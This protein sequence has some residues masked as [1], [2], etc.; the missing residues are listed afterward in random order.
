MKNPTVCWMAP[1]RSS[2]QRHITSEKAPVTK[3][4]MLSLR[5]SITQS[6]MIWFILAVLHSGSWIISFFIRNILSVRILLPLSSAL[7]VIFEALSY[8]TG[9]IR[10]MS[11]LLLC[12]FCYTYVLFHP[13]FFILSPSIE[14]RSVRVNIWSVNPAVA[15]KWLILTRKWSLLKCSKVRRGLYILNRGTVYYFSSFLMIP[16]IL[17]KL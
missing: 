10:S 9:A 17:L 7:T 8:P 14:N 2:T 12:C 3:V 4:P 5:I 15:S 11:L 6:L 16:S 1:K 13:L